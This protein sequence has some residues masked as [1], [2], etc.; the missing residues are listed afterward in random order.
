MR[1]HTHVYDDPFV[2]QAL[3]LCRHDKIV[4]V[5]FVVN[6]VLQVNSW[7]H[8]QIYLTKK[9]LQF[10]QRK[11]LEGWKQTDSG[12]KVH[13]SSRVGFAFYVKDAL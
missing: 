7:E 3:L 13:N 11:Q 12:Y 8:E 2:Q 1:V 5:V 4:R 9:P 6:N 10:N